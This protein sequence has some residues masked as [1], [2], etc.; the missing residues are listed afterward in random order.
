MT[1]T[2]TLRFLFVP[3][4]AI[5][6]AA[7]ATAQGPG[8]RDPRPTGLLVREP[9]A[10]DGYTL[11][12][13][14]KSDTVYLVDM[15]GEPVHQWKTERAPGSEYF[16]DDGSLL[17]C[18]REPGVP[19]F[20]G[21]GQGGRLRRYAWDGTLLW[22]WTFA[23]DLA[24][25]HHDIELTPEG[26][27]LF[28]A[29]EHKD[30]DAAIAAGR[31]PRFIPNAGAWPDFVVEIE[32]LPPND[33]RIVWEWHFWDHLVQDW[34]EE[35]DE[36]DDVM[37]RPERLDINAGLGREAMSRAEFMRLVNLGYLDP[38][39]DQDNLSA[40]WLHC[41]SIDYDPEL[42]LIVLSS[43]NL[44]EIFVIDHSTTTAEAAGSSGGNFGM[45]G[46]ILYRWGN[47]F[48]YRRADRDGQ[49]LFRQHDARFERG[50]EGQLRLTIFDNGA[51]RPGGSHSAVVEIEPPLVDGE[52]VIGE[53]EP[54]E[55]EAPVWD[56]RDP[57]A[58][59]SS[60]IS[61][62]QRLP[63]GN[64]LV[65][66]GDE[67]RV[68]EVTRDKKIVWEFWHDFPAADV[69]GPPAPPVALFRATRIPADHPGLT[70]KGL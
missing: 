20:R 17:R 16:L 7:L 19:R 14:L 65:I 56:Y 30:R 69:E 34:D 5:A 52:F 55:P 12:A 42:D 54:F 15:N 66:E 38:D 33:A 49:T 64:T 11:I 39:A 29:W 45:G 59:Y 32:P 53:E 28:I 31:D 6:F 9:E 62:A 70:G 2:S 41:N 22:D 18:E 4:M 23:D 40:D 68:F 43:P 61:G 1:R 3:A 35:Q 13:P 44:S 57:S 26:T 51:G 21:G 48:N 63:G 8:A 50:P 25:Q 67:G 37:W 60:F 47:P 24:L 46:D 58:F 36:F 10:V 27:I